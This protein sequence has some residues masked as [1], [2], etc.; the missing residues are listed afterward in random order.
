VTTLDAGEPAK[1]AAIT[2]TDCQGKVVWTGTTDVSG[3]ARIQQSLP[4]DAL[5]RC[6]YQLDYRDYSQMG[7]LHFL[8]QGLFITA[9]TEND[10]S[11]V[12]SSWDQGIEAWRFQ[13]VGESSLDPVLGHTIFDRSLLRAGET[14][15][16]KHIL[17]QHTTRGFAPVPQDQMPALVSIQHYGSEQKYEFPLK[18]DAN[19]VAETHW[20]IPK[21]AKLGNYNVLLVEKKQSKKAKRLTYVDREG[22]EHFEDQEYET[23][24]RWVSGNFRVE[25]FRIPLTKGTLQPPAAP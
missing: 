2:I 10:M 7:A 20:A 15:H 5:P 3:I 23:A 14:V 9:R 22:E 8:S 12:H 4:V 17:R 18:W 13:L 1:N 6:S 11:F 19:G 24:R 25:E 16:M 21:D